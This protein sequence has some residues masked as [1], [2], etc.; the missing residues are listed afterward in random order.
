M[1]NQQDILSNPHLLRGH[2]LDQTITFERKIDDY[3]STYFAGNI[4]Y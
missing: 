2:I 1:S 3:L 4:V